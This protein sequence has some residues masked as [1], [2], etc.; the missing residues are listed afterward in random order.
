[1]ATVSCEFCKQPVRTN[2]LSVHQ[3]TAGWVKLRD[4]GGGHGISLA[5]RTR[6][7]AHGYC[8]ERA[9]RGFTAQVT[10]GDQFPEQ[11]T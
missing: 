2:E 10:F 1:M 4:A 11:Q 9:V 5:V 3:W 7:W 8:V 6:H